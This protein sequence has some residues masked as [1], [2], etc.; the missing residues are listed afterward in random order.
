[1]LRIL[2]WSLVT[3]SLKRVVWW[4][5]IRFY[6]SE[7]PLAHQL[8]ML[9]ILRPESINSKAAPENSQSLEFFLKLDHR[10]SISRPNAS[11]TS[12][13]EKN[14]PRLKI[15]EKRL[16]VAQLEVWCTLRR[17]LKIGCA[18]SMVDFC[19]SSNM[20]LFKSPIS[21]W[22]PFGTRAPRSEL[23]IVIFVFFFLFVS[24]HYS[25]CLPSYVVES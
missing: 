15:R 3:R 14:S 24:Y 25:S 19:D 2:L 11:H 23:I 18:M 17:G 7:N 20:L 8:P 13:E 6:I 10:I 5:E 1:M 9:I 12:D 4:K 16:V 21:S 22:L